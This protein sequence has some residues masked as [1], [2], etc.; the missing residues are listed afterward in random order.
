[1]K[2][3]VSYSRVLG[4][5]QL[6][7]EIQ[8]KVLSQCTAPVGLMKHMGKASEKLRKWLS[9]HRH[10]Q[11]FRYFGDCVSLDLQFKEHQCHNIAEVVH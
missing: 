9:S 8:C 1:M 4:W 2:E 5:H 11:T 10:S 6:Q 3:N 7:G